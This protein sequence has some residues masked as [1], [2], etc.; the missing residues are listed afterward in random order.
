M[1][2][3]VAKHAVQHVFADLRPVDTVGSCGWRV[4]AAVPSGS[5]FVSRLFDDSGQCLTAGEV[6]DPVEGFE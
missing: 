1:L 3:G 6:V 2:E 5:G 4:E